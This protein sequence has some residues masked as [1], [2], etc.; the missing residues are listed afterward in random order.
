MPH[1][2]N[3]IVLP[4]LR[5]RADELYVYLRQAILSGE[6]APNQRLVETELA[7]TANVSR[8]PVREA[9]KRLEIDGLVRT[10]SSRGVV[11]AGFSYD[12]LHDLC[13][14]RAGMEGL[15]ARLAAR[16]CT[17]FDIVNLDHVMEET[18]VAVAQKD[19]SRLVE[20]NHAFHEAM[21]R[22]SRNRYLAQELR[23]LR[24]L[25]ERLQ[26]TTLTTPERQQQMLEEHSA[27]VDALRRG[28]AE[29]A[30]HITQQHFF[31]AMAIRL[32]NLAAQEPTPA[33]AAGGAT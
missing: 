10:T 31:R 22:A 32:A 7:R 11:V 15:A 5:S 26:Q 24:S 1:L 23:L 19:V 2:P 25:I 17:E 30:E 12:E 16:S 29:A 8:T 3:S 9:L 18:V 4:G 28:D 13:V 20:L 6:L 33:Q 21:W 27:V 14:A